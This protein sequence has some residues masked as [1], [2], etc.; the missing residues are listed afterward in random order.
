MPWS[1]CPRGPYMA[2]HQVMSARVHSTFLLHARTCHVLHAPPC[3]Y[4]HAHVFISLVHFPARARPCCADVIT[5]QLGGM[6]HVLAESEAGRHV[7]PQL[8]EDVADVISNLYYLLQ[9]HGPELGGEE[10]G[11]Q[12]V[13]DVA[14]CM[15]RALKVRGV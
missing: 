6:T 1:I 13:V 11:A 4:S 14:G 2:L 3:C 10:G 9:R 12:V 15:L 7:A 8:M 5:C